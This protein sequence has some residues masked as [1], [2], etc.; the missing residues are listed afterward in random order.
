MSTL[1]TLRSLIDGAIRRQSEFRDA[2]IADAFRDVRSEEVWFNGGTWE[3][4]LQ[5]DKVSYDLPEDFFGI[6]G[7]VWKLED[8]DSNSRIE[9][10]PMTTD[11]L[12]RYRYGSYDILASAT[13]DWRFEF[14]GEPVA[15]AIDKNGRFFLTAPTPSSASAGDTVKF[16]YT[17]D[18]GTPTYT[19]ATTASPGLSVTVTLLGPNGETLPTTFTSPWL[20]EALD[21]LK[22]RAIYKLLTAYHGGDDKSLAMAQA[23]L[24]RYAEGLK[25]I[26]EETSEIQSVVRPTGWL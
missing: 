12:E 13:D 11:D 4:A 16:R 17:R 25:R 7:S 21:V 20:T 18:L 8:G 19:A 15:Y 23:A 22:D 24:M 26:R 10:V 5:A 9:M 3:F 14:T 6:R 2:A 1:A